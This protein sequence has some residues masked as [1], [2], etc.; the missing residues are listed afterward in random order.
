MLHSSKMDLL[1]LDSQEAS[2]TFNNRK[3]TASQSTFDGVKRSDVFRKKIQSIAM[4]TS[5]IKA[6]DLSHAA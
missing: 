6:N 3:T 4:A 2:T 1:D 5:T